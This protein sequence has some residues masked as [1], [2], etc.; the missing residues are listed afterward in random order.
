MIENDA[1]SLNSDGR[2]SQRPLITI[3]IPVLD[4]ADNID[5]LYQRLC[6]LGEAMAERCDLEFVFSDN[7]SEDL[8]WTKLSQLA[9]KDSRVRAIRFSKNVGFQRSILANFL[10]SRGDAVLQIDADLQDPPELLGEFLDL[11]RSGYRVVYGIRKMRPEGPL[12]RWFRRFGY[13]FIDK[14]SEHPI[15]RDVGDFRLIDRTVV[16]A[17]VK[18]NSPNPYL[19]GMIAGL[20]FSQ[21]GIPYNR[22]ARMRGKSKFNMLRLTQLGITA[23]VNHSVV[24]LRIA[25]IVGVVTLGISVIGGFYFI[26]GKLIQP[27]YPRGLAS[28]HVL[29]LFGIGLQSFLLGIIGE[30]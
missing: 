24:P 19:R 23:I 25:S 29:V 22:D 5:S 6:R 2:Q 7:H 21:T 18:M 28:T 9:S 11:W 17:L 14:V 30:Y 15:P 13:W 8:T 27:D 4:E 3:S 10:H 16:K 26:I 12:L 1:L 20:G